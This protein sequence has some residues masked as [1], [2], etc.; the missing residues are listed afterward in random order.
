MQYY[1]EFLA[2]QQEQAAQ[3]VPGPV[4][5]PVGGQQPPTGQPQAGAQPTDV[6]QTQ[7]GNSIAMAP[8]VQGQFGATGAIV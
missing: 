7:A 8:A 2:N 6:S 5:P 1:Q 4:Q 3:G